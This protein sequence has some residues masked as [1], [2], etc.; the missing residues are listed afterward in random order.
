MVFVFIS[1]LIS[2]K[3]QSDNNWRIIFISW[4]DNY[5][6]ENNSISEMNEINIFLESRS[7]DTTLSPFKR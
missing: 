6:K 3:V 4:L 1:S 2:I 7:S 5:L